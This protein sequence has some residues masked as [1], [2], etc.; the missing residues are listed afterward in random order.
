VTSIDGARS[1][2]DAGDA[3]G[4]DQYLAAL[5]QAMTLALMPGISVI[6]GGGRWVW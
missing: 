2:V 5:L 3:A 4:L 6:S 1:A